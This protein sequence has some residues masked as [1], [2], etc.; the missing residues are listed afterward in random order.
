MIDGSLT[1]GRMADGCPS[2]SAVR[3]LGAANRL[4]RIK[5]DEGPMSA[6]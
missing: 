3:R 1:L 4:A 5:R 2:D 6:L